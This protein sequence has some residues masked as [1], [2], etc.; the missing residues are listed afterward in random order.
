MLAWLPELGLLLVQGRYQDGSSSPY[1]GRRRAA[2]AF[3]IVAGGETSVFEQVSDGRS[4]PLRLDLEPPVLDGLRDLVTARR[5][6]DADVP[7]GVRGHGPHLAMSM[8][9]GNH[10]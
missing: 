8:A 1:A 9:G 3:V 6:A 4:P 10:W 5:G 7:A 2:V